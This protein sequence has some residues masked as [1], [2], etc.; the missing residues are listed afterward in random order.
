MHNPSIMSKALTLSVLTLAGPLQAQLINGSFEDDGS[1][2]LTGWEWTCADPGQPDEAAP[3]SGDWSATKEAGHTKGCFPSYLYQ[4]LPGVPNGATVILSGWVR[5]D[6]LAPCLGAWIGLGTV[7][8]GAFTLEEN[9]GTVDPAW[10]Y[11]SLTD[12]AQIGTSDTL[13]AV[14]TAGMIGGPINPT[15]GH[16]DGLEMALGMGVE[17]IDNWNLHQHLDPQSGL[18]TVAT[19]GP[20][21]RSMHLFDATGRALV[22]RY[23][24]RDRAQA[25]LDI[26]DLHTGVYLLNVDSDRGD[27]VVRF[28]KR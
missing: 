7:N 18:L 15:P 23:T 17:E 19:G 28:V 24:R 12:T 5:C 2:S 8:N 6:S 4:R 10:T 9:T 27:R 11:V 3:A 26:G 16:F 25:T 13:I 14:L 22:L 21:I 20:S 1:P